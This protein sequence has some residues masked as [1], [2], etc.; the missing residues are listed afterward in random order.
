MLEPEDVGRPG[1]ERFRFHADRLFHGRPADAPFLPGVD[2]VRSDR[3]NS[4]KLRDLMAPDRPRLAPTP[5]LGRIGADD[6]RAGMLR[7]P[8]ETVIVPFRYRPGPSVDDTP[9]FLRWLHATECAPTDGQKQSTRNLT[10][11][12]V[13][14]CHPTALGDCVVAVLLPQTGRRSLAPKSPTHGGPHD[15]HQPAS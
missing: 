7:Q 3:E 10:W 13:Q 8:L 6:E 15:H 12:S 14:E 4:P 11:A 2:L 5:P 1:F 9:N